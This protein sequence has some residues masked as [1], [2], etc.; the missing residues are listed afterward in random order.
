MK[1]DKIIKLIEVKG[2]Q[3]KQNYKDGKGTKNEVFQYFAGYVN[4]FKDLGEISN[5]EMETILNVFM[6]YLVR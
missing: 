1:I 3:L 2:C 4:T 5:S 6:W